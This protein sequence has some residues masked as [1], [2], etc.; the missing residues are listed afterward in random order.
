MKKFE[1][2]KLVRHK[3]ICGAKQIGVSSLFLGC[4]LL[5]GCVS[6]EDSVL[7]EGTEIVSSN[8]VIKENLQSGTELLD[9]DS[10]YENDVDDSVVT[11]YLTVRQGNKADNTNHTWNEV[12]EHSTMY[13]DE[14]EMDRNKTEA[15]LQVG[16]EKGP[17]IDE[18]GYNM[19][20]PNAIVSIRGQTSSQGLAKSYKI[21]MKDDSGE[22]NNQKTI[23]LNK[24]IY[25]SVR[26]RNKLAY[27][28][29]EELPGLMSM[30]TQFVHLYVK[31]ETVASDTEFVD[32][33]LFTQVEQPNKR[34][35]ESHGMNKLGHL[36]KIN[37]C[38]FYKYENIIKLTSDSTYNEKEISTLIEAKG[39]DD[40][41][42]L[43]AMLAD[44]NNYEI[45]IETTLGKWFNEDNLTSWMAFHILVGNLDTQSRNFYLYSALNSEKWYFISWD[46]DDCFTRANDIVGEGN[47]NGNWEKGI[48]NYWGNVLFKRLLKS[49]SYRQALDQKI[50]E[51]R[52]II[53]KEKLSN[54][55][56][57]YDKVTWK[58]INQ[59]PDL[60]NTIY[61]SKEYGMIRDEIPNEIEKNYQLYKQSLKEPMPFYIWEIEKSEGGMKCTWDSSFDLN[62]ESITYSFE[63]AK[64]Y[65][66]QDTIVKNMNVTTPEIEFPSLEPGQYFVRVIANNQSGLKQVAFDKYNAENS[67]IQGVKCFYVLED[68]QISGEAKYEQ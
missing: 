9:N 23:V 2:L 14:K 8:G 15:L 56:K 44:V 25:D 28:L 60:E 65:T 62:N 17:L 11:M 53:T 47:V 59:M 24:H 36:Y 3:L 40:H 64:D 29:L 19:S 67:V 13:Y 49:E 55:V 50:E 5:T 66:F 18:L 1:R 43:I 39:D 16:D 4:M 38:E 21:E 68:G 41:S 45:P 33:G 37:Y 51:Y 48:S 12:N 46:N 42:K 32:Y 7:Q 63:L 27:D 10:L 57:K 35:L 58:Y 6:Q 26:F 31:D 52:A 34:Y 30:R 20:V 54:M 22:W 61:T